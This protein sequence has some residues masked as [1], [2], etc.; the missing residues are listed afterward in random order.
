MF[1]KI[2]ADIQEPIQRA[3]V[4]ALAALVIAVAALFVAM[5][6]GAKANG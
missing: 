5:G 3:N 6:K 4:L 2:K 1:D